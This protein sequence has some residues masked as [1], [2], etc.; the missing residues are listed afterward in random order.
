MAE[1]IRIFRPRKPISAR[2]RGRSQKYPFGDLAV[3]QAFQADASYQ[4]LYS[5]LRHWYSHKCPG[6]RDPDEKCPRFR[7]AKIEGG[8]VVMRTE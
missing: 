4:T 7:I 3:G 8:C 2:P 1:K 5:C 6:H